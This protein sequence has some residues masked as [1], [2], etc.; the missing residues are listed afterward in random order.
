MNRKKLLSTLLT[1]KRGNFCF[2]RDAS[3]WSSSV[4]WSDFWS[5]PSDKG[6]I[7]SPLKE[8]SQSLA[9]K[10]MKDCQ[11]NRKFRRTTELCG[12]FCRDAVIDR[13]TVLSYNVLR[14]HS[15]YSRNS[16]M[17]KTSVP[18]FLKSLTFYRRHYS[19]NSLN[20]GQ[21]I[22]EASSE[23]LD[24]MNAV[25]LPP[26]SGDKERSAVDFAPKEFP[27]H[28]IRNFSIIAHIDH[29]KSTL[30]DRMMEMTGAIIPGV[31]KG[32]YLDKLQVERERGIT[33]KAQTASLIYTNPIDKE[34]YLLNL[35]DTPGHVDFS[36]EVS[37]SLAACDG[38]LLLVDSTQGVQAQTV[39]NFFLAFE[40]NLAIVPVLNKIDMDSAEPEKVAQQI[41]EAFD[42]IEPSQCLQVSAKSGLGVD[43]LLQAIVEE[44]PCPDG[45]PEGPTRLLLFD[46]FMDT[47]RGVICLI[48]V[49]DGLLKKGDRVVSCSSGKEWEILE[50]GILSPEPRPTGVLLTGQVS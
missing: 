39:A 31:H 43:S 49:V 12:V 45:N 41:H 4:L 8:S 15:H 26:G 36:Y 5:S 42:V 14:R 13:E 46:A 38:C 25:P 6:D 22:A 10:K 3:V 18:K 24:K 28:K 35:I 20:R 44:I 50:I 30:A 37:R 40:Q 2:E 34:R 48:T 47:F 19:S 33:V 27:K 7:P 29:G 11:Q 23:E 17:R 16:S 9:F 21:K 32:Q 1:P